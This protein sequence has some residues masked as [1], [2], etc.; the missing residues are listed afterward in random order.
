MQIKAS[1]DPQIGRSLRALRDFVT[2]LE[3]DALKASR[4]F[5]ALRTGT[6]S[7]A[8]GVSAVTAG[9]Q[10]AAEKT[11]LLG[12][13]LID[14]RNQASSS[15]RAFSKSGQDLSRAFAQADRGPKDV[16][17]SLRG[18]REE[19]RGTGNTAAS[20][21][22]RMKV[23]AGGAG[24]AVEDLGASFR[25]P[26]ELLGRLAQSAVIGT[27]VKAAFTTAARS[28]IEFEAELRSL[29]TITEMSDEALKSYGENLRTLSLELK[30]TTGAAENARAAY[31]VASAGFVGAAENAAVLEATLKAASAGNVQAAEAAKLIS[32]SLR[33][34]GADAKEA[35]KF[36]NV[37]FTTVKKGITTFPELSASLGS[38]TGIAA[39]A[40]ISIEELGAAV[41][42]ATSR[43][44]RTSRAIDG[45]RGAISN[46]LAPSDQ[47]KKEMERLGIV[48][49][50]QTLKQKGLLGTLKEIAQANGG[51]AESF[52]LLLGDVQAFA[53]ALALTSDG[54]KLFAENLKEMQTNVTALSDAVNEKSKSM[55]FSIDQFKVALE[56]TAGAVGQTFI[57]AGKALVDSATSVLSTFAQLPE[58]VRSFVAILGT[59]AVAT[60]ATV[61]VVKL[62]ATATQLETIQLGLNT[63]AKTLNTTVTTANV[64][65]TVLS[66]AALVRKNVVLAATTL[67]ARAAALSISGMAAAMRTSAATTGLLGGAFAGVAGVVL[68]GGYA[69]YEYTKIVQEQTAAN[70][71]L[72]DIELRMAKGQKDYAK[73]VKLTTAE[74][75]EQK[76][77]AEELTDALLANLERQEAA[78]E[79]GNTAL[80]ERLRQENKDL[81]KKRKALATDEATERKQNQPKTATAAI[82]EDEQ[83]K[84]EKEAEERRKELLDAELSRIQ[85]LKNRRELNAQEEID[86]LGRV[87][88]AYKLKAEERRQIEER[89]A[90][91]IG[92]QRAKAEKDANKA[93]E[94]RLEKSLKSGTNIPADIQKN[95]KGTQEAVRAYDTAI[96]KVEE[97]QRTNKALLS[98]FPELGQKA[99]AAL[100]KL[101][102]DRA[103]AETERL[104]TNFKNLQNELKQVQAE[105]T[106]SA[107]KLEAIK[108]QIV[109]VEREQ[110][111]G[112]IPLKESEEELNRLARERLTLEQTITTQKL[113]QSGELNELET[114]GIRQEIEM[115]E[116]LRE[117]GFDVTNDLMLKREELY[118][119]RLEK[120]RLEYEAERETAEDKLHVDE[121][122]QRKR[123]NLERAHTVEVSKEF[124]KRLEA[125]ATPSKTR[126]A[127][128]EEDKSTKKSSRTEVGLGSIGTS[129][130]FF[131]IDATPVKGRS[132]EDRE[133]REQREAREAAERRRLFQAVNP[134]AS[135]SVQRAEEAKAIDQARREAEKGSKFTP[136]DL[137][138]TQEG[139][140]RAPAF[141]AKAK[142]SDPSS[143]ITNA[144]SLVSESSKS[145]AAPTPKATGPR[146]E[147]KYYFNITNNLSVED[148]DPDVQALA[149]ITQNLAKKE[150]RVKDLQG[151]SSGNS[152][153]GYGE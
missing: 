18:L 91:L 99:E 122:Y 95:Q 124:R 23:E 9:A 20:E 94:E 115:L 24:K 137:F 13:N 90:K 46:L 67:Q 27:A 71:K 119:F 5:D 65:A 103:G 54:G 61:K 22:R 39:Q 148:G 50:E 85:V 109:K 113:R 96:K 132:A 75:R 17:A 100:E 123:Q 26:Q 59:M 34:Y 73:L 149:R 80:L 116:L 87:L 37:F 7:S 107:E 10:K 126:Q 78:K 104:T 141:E 81:R 101:R 11:S 31:D 45:L 70:E 140:Y 133:Q 28:A 49:N 53:A 38:V 12:R 55:Q 76:I 63:A 145:A 41:A 44:I 129:A 153:L 33:A 4:A 146:T 21:F 48:V 69:L 19:L 131:S 77:A 6:Q 120:L 147:N 134:R 25:S 64:R 151:R 8:S 121:V 135:L 128:S 102:A 150:K 2:G 66:T 111:A 130:S 152:P 110:L 68:A 125:E 43:G 79:A 60:G 35:E 72:L 114:E 29:N 16:G 51:S 30:T 92:E 138:G 89:V 36:T 47:A 84:A 136:S 112:N 142:A 105:A 58:P 117:Q 97:W 14:L 106:T 86:A 144:K 108:E 1:V 15:G 98:Q 62:L 57:P 139:R 82:G 143:A 74:L 32:G 88:E 127:S 56:A 52:K 40:G 3:K 83:K 93:T 118:Q 42:T